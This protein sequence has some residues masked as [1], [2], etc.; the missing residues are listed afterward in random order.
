[1][2]SRHSRKPFRKTVGFRLTIW[3]SGI[4]IFSS[5]L[6]FGFSYFYVSSS[7]KNQDQKAIQAELKELSSLYAMGGMDFVERKVTAHRKF[8]KEKSFLVRIGSSSNETLLLILP[9]QWMEFDIK[10]LQRIDTHPTITWTI[11]HGQHANNAFEV[12]SILLADNH[13][14]QVG[15]S[16]QNRQRILGHFRRYFLFI[17]APLIALAFLVGAFLAIRALRPVR[18]IITAVRSA[19]S[20]KMDTRIPSTGTDDELGELVTLFNQML[21]RIEALIE[22]M[23]ASLD[24]VAHDLRTPMT[25]LRGVAEIALTSGENHK[26]CRQA[27]A[28]CIEESERILKMLNTLMDIS[29]AEMGAM[30]L[31]LERVNLRDV[32]EHIVEVYSYIAEDRG[33]DLNASFGQ[34]L[35]V[36]ADPT[37]LYQIIANLIDNALKYTGHGG[38]I[39]IEA[40]RKDNAII[41]TVKD[42]GIGIAK[43]DISRIWDR[44]YRCDQSRSQPGLGLGLSLVKAF[45]EAH[46]GHVKVM[47]Q[48]AGGSTFTVIIPTAD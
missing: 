32:I 15:K 33:I 43:K 23:R 5:V 47:S 12:G 7:L 11:L 41:V 17:S 13:V 6:L 42:T 36:Q 35:S 10:E 28:E 4:F 30:R 46:Q 27:L 48:P 8:E 20:G 22:G 39:D 3:Y 24:N 45:V 44:S 40:S 26:V 31:K 19:T 16:I 2:F 25:R 18:H 14:L 37:R 9:N 34:G 29:E 1:M 21:H 38:K